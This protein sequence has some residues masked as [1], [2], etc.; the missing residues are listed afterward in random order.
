MKAI[1]F[2]L[3]CTGSAGFALHG[4]PFHARARALS[5]SGGGGEVDDSF[6]GKSLSR[7][8]VAFG[9][10]AVGFVAAVLGGRRYGRCRK[11]GGLP[12][13]RATGEELGVVSVPAA[14]G[15]RL[16]GNLACRKQL[17]RARARAL[18][19]HESPAAE[20]G[21]RRA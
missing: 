4:A 21:E 5:A 15:Q 9:T 1:V 7:R 6:T 8:S 16:A 19:A 20:V 11:G 2:A 13:A 17:R 12:L 18:L 14:V 3:V 10:A